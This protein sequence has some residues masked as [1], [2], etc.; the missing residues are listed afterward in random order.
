MQNDENGALS[1]DERDR[2]LISLANDFKNVYFNHW[3]HELEMQRRSVDNP[4]SSENLLLTARLREYLAPMQCKIVDTSED[5][6]EI[7]QTMSTLCDCIEDI[8]KRFCNAFSN[9]DTRLQAL[10]RQLMQIETKKHL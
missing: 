10:E 2:L 9:I 5:M 3:R 6:Q 4:Y 7:L 8:N 1:S